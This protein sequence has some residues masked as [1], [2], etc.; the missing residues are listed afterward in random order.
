MSELDASIIIPTYNRKASLLETLGSLAQQRWPLDRFEVIVV[1]DGSSDGTETIADRHLPLTLRLIRQANQGSA[2]ARNTGA[3]AAQGHLLIFLDD[4]MLA[5]PD[6]VAGL[7]EE[8]AAHQRIVG[9]GRELAYIPSS[10]TPF[11]RMAAQAA[12]AHSQH[13]SGA[14]VNFTDCVTNNLSV[15]REDFFLIGMMQD[16]AGDGPTWWGDVDF[17]YRAAQ[18]GFRFRRSSKAACYH[19]DY[20]M[21]DLQTASQRL[22]KVSHMAVALF[23]KFPDLTA[24]LPMFRDK[25]PVD[26]RRDSAS[27]ITRKLLRVLVSAPPV[28]WIMEQI[29]YRLEEGNGSPLLLDSLYRW[30]TGAYIF[31]GFRAGLRNHPVVGRR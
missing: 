5:E 6:Y 7:I 30:I 22:Y 21:R 2:V 17:G 16:V 31:R 27:L 18:L 29:A 28:V 3:Q 4:D 15:L 8:H 25:A 11:A 23:Q 10:A 20:S 1:D 13:Q 19:R 12:A 14:F 24:C 9:M 26:W